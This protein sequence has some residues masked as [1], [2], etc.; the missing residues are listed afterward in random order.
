MSPLPGGGEPLDTVSLILALL[1][2]IYYRGMYF[3]GLGKQMHPRDP[4]QNYFREST[5]WLFQNQICVWTRQSLQS[6][7][8]PLG[9]PSSKVGNTPSWAS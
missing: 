8:N 3:R 6:S 4:W 5:I 9:I 7:A 2:E 1:W